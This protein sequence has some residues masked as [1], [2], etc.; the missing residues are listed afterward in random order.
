M[1]EQYRRADS[2][3]ASGRERE[4]DGECRSEMNNPFGWISR[5]EFF[6]SAFSARTARQL[7]LRLAVIAG[8][9]R[10]DLERI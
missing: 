9:D 5:L 3:R 1:V 2:E 7:S 4:R 8:L 6:L 10:S